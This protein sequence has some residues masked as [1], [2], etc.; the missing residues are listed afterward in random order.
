MGQ[1]KVSNFCLSCFSIPGTFH[2]GTCQS[3]VDRDPSEQITPPPPTD[4]PFWTEILSANT[5]GGKF[6]TGMHSC[7]FLFFF[8]GVPVERRHVYN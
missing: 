7:F 1:N 6:S 5:A 4:T 8:T 2:P 3:P